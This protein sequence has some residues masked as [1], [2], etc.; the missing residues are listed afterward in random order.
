[1]FGKKLGPHPLPI[2]T[3]PPPT[4]TSGESDIFQGLS[5]LPPLGHLGPLQESLPLACCVTLINYYPSLGLCFSTRIMSR[6]DYGD[7]MFPL[8][9][10]CLP[11]TQRGIHKTLAFPGIPVTAP[12][13][14]HAPSLEAQ[15]SLRPIV[16]L[17]DV[18]FTTLPNGPCANTCLLPAVI[19]HCLG[20][21]GGRQLH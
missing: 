9:D 19:C 12:Q 3:P 5:L 21:S 10:F 20:V 1:M 2:P 15:Q 14:P 16:T 8:T 6:L 4:P 17:R 7:A 18:L 11:I 13:G